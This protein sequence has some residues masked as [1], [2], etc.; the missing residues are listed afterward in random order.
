MIIVRIS[1]SMDSARHRFRNSWDLCFASEYAYWIPSVS[2]FDIEC[3]IRSF[4]SLQSSNF[5][6]ML[7]RRHTK[8]FHHLG[9]LS[10]TYREILQLCDTF[11]V[12][13]CTNIEVNLPLPCFWCD[14]VEDFFE[15][16][17]SRCTKFQNLPS[18]SCSTW[19]CR[20]SVHSIVSM[21]HRCWTFS[22]GLLPWWFY[23]LMASNEW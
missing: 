13:K 11:S 16:S 10:W 21:L 4:L 6:S 3:A 15:N 9:T 17:R 18:V 12:E 2:F 22:V 7:H 14:P 1:S 20:T 19:I 23:D 8:W 5:C